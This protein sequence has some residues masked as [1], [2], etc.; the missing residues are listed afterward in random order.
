MLTIDGV[1]YYLWTPQ[2]EENEFHP[3]V[4]EHYKQIFGEGSFYFD[5]K[6]LIKSPS[7][8]GSIPD[9]YVI[10]LSKPAEWYVVEN[11]L[12]SHPVYDH[13]VK[14]L[15]KFI[16]GIENQNS[17]NQILDLLYEEI[18]R[19]PPLEAEV[20]KLT[21]TKDIYHYLSKLLQNSPRIV[22]IIDKETDEIREAVRA[23]RY[24]TNIVEFKTYAREN[25]ENVR[26]HVFNSLYDEGIYATKATGGQKTRREEGEGDAERHRLRLEFWTKLVEK[27]KTKTAL[28]S[29]IKPSKNH[30]LQTGAGKGGLSY[31]YTILGHA[32]GVEL[33]ID[34]SNQSRNKNIFD[35][36]LGKKA[37]IESTFGSHLDWQRLNNKRACRILKGTS[38]DKGLR[39]REVW[40]AIQ[41]EMIDAMIRFEK[42]FREPIRQLK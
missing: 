23:L 32:A 19:A 38:E 24:E 6:H 15:T 39:D 33:Y 8:I 34:T 22:V 27:S 30:W 41:D 14:Q 10:R 1:R 2:D 29:K 13:V 4:K 35:E 7:G 31:V 26:A 28:F 37:E 18:C 12:S 5:V 11:E 3:L 40:P 21:E 17:R 16:N 25:A 9:A 20:R 42:A 36:L